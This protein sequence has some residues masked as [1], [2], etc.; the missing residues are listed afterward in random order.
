[1]AEPA[2]CPQ[3][4]REKVPFNESHFQVLLI[5]TGSLERLIAAAHAVCERYPSAVCI[6]WLRAEDLIQG[7]A[8]GLFS[9]VEVIPSRMDPPQDPIGDLCILSFED[10]FGAGYWTLR[11]IPL[12]SGI[13][14]I[15]F[16]NR[17]RR[18]REFSRFG[19]RANTIAACFILYPVFLCIRT[20]QA[21][22]HHTCRYIDIVALFAL[23]GLAF[24]ARCMWN[25]CGRSQRMVSSSGTPQTAQRVV[26]FIPSLG[27]GGAQR[28]LLSYLRHIDR[29]RWQ[30]EIVTIDTADT[31]FVT[32]FASLGVPVTFFTSTF[33]LPHAGVVWQLVRFLHGYQYA[34]LHSWLHY[35]VALGAI[36][37]GLAGVPVVIGSLRSERPGRFPWFYPKWQRA[38]DVLTGPLQ[39]TIIANSRAVLED[40]RQWAF[41]PKKKLVTIYNGIGAEGLQ[42]IDEGKRRQ[43]KAELRLPPHEPVVGI[44]GR[45]SPEKDHATFLASAERVLQTISDAVFLIVG[46]GPLRTWVDSE[47]QRRGMTG[48]VF[49]LG[50]RR[51]AK[52]IMQIL[53]VLVL[54]SESEGLPNVLLEGAASGIPAVTTAAGGAAE[55]VVDGETGYVVPCGDWRQ[56]GDRI[57]DLLKNP[58]LRKL[59]G[60]AAQQRMRVC[61]EPNAIARMIEATYVFEG[62]QPCKSSALTR[63]GIIS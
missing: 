31:F 34:V 2:R 43:L 55:V 61:F 22:W 35:A 53:D 40:N 10:R 15:G 4:Q 54:T 59:F 23:A 56:V 63:G 41:L 50:E 52:Q 24:L 12:R 37:G 58:Q 21:A 62:A 33:R 39:T 29:S 48:R 17:S 11:N 28:Q 42:R 30:P 3:A 5:Q 46:D 13:R 7:R 36:G 14:R 26:L 9:H 38:I 16:Y 32:E 8:S 18:L 44:V 60:E 25:V 47:I 49:A 57:V 6:G 20:L 51:D 27:M 45:L 19:W 1:V